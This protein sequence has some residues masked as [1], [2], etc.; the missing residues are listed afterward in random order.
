MPTEITPSISGFQSSTPLYLLGTGI[1]KKNLYL[2]ELDIY[3]IG[4]VVPA[5]GFTK[6]GEWIKNPTLP[7]SHYLLKKDAA[8]TKSQDPNPIRLGLLLKFCR[9]VG[10]DLFVDAFRSAFQGIDA[11]AFDLF[12]VALERTMGADGLKTGEEMQFYFLEDGEIILTKNGA[13]G[14][15]VNVEALTVRLLDVYTESSRAVSKELC[16]NL[17][18]FA[19]SV[20]Q[21]N[22]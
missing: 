2:V 5:S 1:R 18:Q 22:I 8:P 12:K 7:L 13:I 9:S 17:N 19:P 3:R 6:V 4:V 16:D 20:V 14:G 21:M 15:R 11:A 10:K